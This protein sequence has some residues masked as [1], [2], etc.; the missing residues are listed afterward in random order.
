MGHG[1]T[2]ERCVREI[3]CAVQPETCG[4]LAARW[5]TL[6]D[7]LSQLADYLTAP[8]KPG[9][10]TPGQ[11]ERPAHSLTNMLA[12]WK[13]EGGAAY[14]EWV[15]QLGRRTA[16]LGEEAA[17]FSASMQRISEYLT[18]SAEA[19][20]V[21]VRGGPSSAVYLL[22]GDT[23]VN[24]SAASGEAFRKSL[25]GD[26]ATSPASYADGAFMKLANDVT[27]TVQKSGGTWT[28]GEARQATEDLNAWYAECTTTATT[29]ASP[30]PTA[31][32]DEAP[33]LLLATDPAP[34]PGGDG[35]APAGGGDGGA[36]RRASGLAGAG[37]GA[38]SLIG[39]GGGGAAAGVVDGAGALGG[40]RAAGPDPS[41]SGIPGLVSPAGRG[42]SPLT[43]PGAIVQA[44]TRQ[45]PGGLIGGVGGGLGGAGGG[46]DSDAELDQEDW[47]LETDMWQLDSD[48]P[49]AVIDATCHEPR[50]DPKALTEP[51]AWMR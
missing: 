26:Y 48:L 29:G 15:A 43:S 20:P 31:M 10:A 21:P 45:N 24:A 37:A 46:W 49:P 32:N 2:W 28:R 8:P 30:L 16:E 17:K 1:W 18:K 35:P 36:G 3:S 22:P 33:N 25:I 39:L 5:R 13:G 50:P 23:G 51:E 47:L 44:A 7:S 6:S 12:G 14:L 9:N 27:A 4:D 42:T 40:L 11:S 41:S 19:I 38:T 34:A